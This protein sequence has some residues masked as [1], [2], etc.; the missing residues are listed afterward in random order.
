[1]TQFSQFIP[2]SLSNRAFWETIREETRFSALRAAL[3]Q[4]AALTSAPA[5]PLASD[6]LAARRC[7]D[8][9]ILDRWW[10]DGRATLAALAAR[11]LLRGLEPDDPDDPLLNA[12]WVQATQAT[13]VVSAHLPGQ[14][15]PA[16]DH[17]TIDLAAAEMAAD[18]AEMCETLGPWM[19]SVSG[20]LRARL[21]HEIDTRVLT[22]FADN[23]QSYGWESGGSNWT[24]VCAGS[25]LAACQSFAA[26]GLP[27][28]QAQRRAL[29]ALSQ[30]LKH[31]FTEHGECDEGV[32]YWGY[33]LAYAVLGW[34]RLTPEEYAAEVDHNRLRLVA[35]YPHRAHLFGD[36]FFAGNDGDMKNTCPAWLAE[37]LAQAEGQDWLRSWA[38]RSGL[39]HDAPSFAV[40]LRTLAFPPSLQ[41][42]SSFSPPRTAYLPDQQTAIL[43]T[44]TS[45]G[46]MIGILS[47]GH[48]AELHNHNDIGQFLMLLNEEIIVPDLG[49]RYYTADFFGPQRYT[50]LAA[51]SRGHNCP[52]IDGCEQRTGAEA[53]ATV[54]QWNAAGGSLTLEAAAAYPA[55]AGLVSWTRSLCQ[56]ED[57]RGS[58]MHVSDSF[59]THRSGRPLISRI[60]ST[61]PPEERTPGQFW[62][63][64]LVLTVTPLARSTTLTPCDG[65]N[66]GLRSFSGQTLY[67]LDLAYETDDAGHLSVNLVFRPSGN[68]S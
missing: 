35:D 19:D 42:P 21:L 50:Y 67:A 38:T 45:Q 20:T 54:Q 13:W 59:A 66:E 11:R 44:T 14:D 58:A 12:L 39:P 55:E 49:N 40:L 48:N 16:T 61:Y 10:R 27:R 62:L 68:L 63:G 23:P 3:E 51:S 18:L 57:V 2:P 37:T 8:R 25:I 41:V 34:M 15:L 22:P 32:G 7:N 4:R 29:N 1:M 46:E 26:M 56:G 6:F 64:P 65:S 43:R 31:A 5:P 28:P 33:G 53:K 47:G 36:M 60:W 17:I 9:A 30:Y 52:L 24:G